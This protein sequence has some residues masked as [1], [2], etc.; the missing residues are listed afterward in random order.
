MC[1]CG[2]GLARKNGEEW[3]ENMNGEKQE[4][5]VREA[6]R[7]NVRRSVDIFVSELIQLV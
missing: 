3:V 2:G 1:V 4:E 6:E 5:E 7:R